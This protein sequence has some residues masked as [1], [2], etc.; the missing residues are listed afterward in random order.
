MNNISYGYFPN[1]ESNWM[2]V[3]F[4]KLSEIKKSTF[5]DIGA[6]I[7]QTLLQFR[8]IFNELSYIAFEPNL[9]CIYYMKYLIEK[10]KI[11]NVSLIP[12]G[13]YNKNCLMD[14]FMESDIDAG[15]TIRLK[16]RPDFMYKNK[17]IVPMFDF[18]TVIDFVKLKEIGI[19]KIDVE[20]AEYKVLK[21]IKSHL[22][23]YKPIIIC[24]V[25]WAHKKD[26]L[27]SNETRNR[28]IENLMEEENYSI[29][30]IIKNRNQNEI[31]GL[32]HIKKFE[33]KIITLDNRDLCDYKFIHNTY[34]KQL[35]MI[36]HQ[37]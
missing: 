3:L 5:I 10:N 14:L 22:Q 18:A 12:A 32:L 30:Q 2:S 1:D 37:C 33:N 36:F 4:Y 13:L 9:S 19:I 25:L 16:T 34:I 29:F 11:K 20:G 8:S 6:N 35:N 28:S 27:E 23:E 31:E 15:A 21:S 7:G 17:K 26:G 24:E